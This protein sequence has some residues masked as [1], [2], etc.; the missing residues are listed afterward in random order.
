MEIKNL[1]IAL[2]SLCCTVSCFAEKVKGDG[3]IVTR[4][5]HVDDFDSIV[6]GHNIEPKG[7]PFGGKKKH[8]TF[9][10]MQTLGT[11]SLQITMD[12]NL[13][14]LL[15][16]A[17]TGGRIEI[18]AKGNGVKIQ[19][20]LLKI[21]GSSSKL[22]YVDITGCINFVS[23]NQLTSDKLSV[24]ISG[25]G[26]VTIDDFTCEEFSCN[27]SGV[28]NIYLS[29]KV[30]SAD[31]NVSGVGKVYAFDCQVENLRCDVSG[32][33]GM[34]VWATDNLKANASGVGSIKY[35]G[36]PKTVSNASGIGRIKPVDD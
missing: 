33:G 2:L 12:E 22:S 9:N 35:R 28:G 21:S 30:K 15:D 4:M 23:E 10:Y 6:I 14:P 11:V 20:T 29:G 3:G 32:V 24:D 1:W 26:D 25:V 8:P 16:V 17:Q 7:N 27:V 13:F 34:K 18:R 19:P 36:N 5:I 31:Y